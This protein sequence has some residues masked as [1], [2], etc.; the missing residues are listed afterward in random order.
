M[1]TTLGCRQQDT[2]ILGVVRREMLMLSLSLS[3][4]P[5]LKE[6]YP[7]RGRERGFGQIQARLSTRQ[8][9]V[10]LGMSLQE[11][12]NGLCNKPC[13]NGRQAQALRAILTR[14]DSNVLFTSRRLHTNLTSAAHG[15]GFAEFS[16]GHVH[17]SKSHLVQQGQCFTLNHSEKQLLQVRVL[18]THQQKWCFHGQQHL[19]LS[20]GC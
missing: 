1:L 2:L 9:A 17:F 11:S 10:C 14:C 18:G 5:P 15:N 8:F 16:N 6:M 19:P 4:F 12:K 7:G 3:L 13:H 20:A